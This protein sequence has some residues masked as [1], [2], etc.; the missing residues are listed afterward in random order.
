[1]STF[2]YDPHANL[3]WAGE[4][5]FPALVRSWDDLDYAL[6]YATV[7]HHTRQVIVPCENGWQ[8]SVVWGSA[9]YGTNY[10][11]GLPGGPEFTD[12]PTTVECAVIGPGRDGLTPIGD[13]T[14]AGWCTPEDV[15]H[16]I[17]QVATFPSDPAAETPEIDLGATER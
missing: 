12:S 14:V 3:L 2:R 8:V 4:R 7:T 1:M 17:A 5:P 13:D 11:A 6:D 15:A 10:Q 16:L 9:S